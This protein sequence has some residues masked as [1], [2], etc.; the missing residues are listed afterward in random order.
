MKINHILV[1]PPSPEGAERSRPKAQE[2]FNHYLHKAIDAPASLPAQ[3][4]P[5]AGLIQ[6]A[7][8]LSRP[9]PIARGSLEA[10]SLNQAEALLNRLDEYQASLADPKVT[11]K[12]AFLDLE[13][14][15]SGLNSLSS[16]LEKL[17]TDSQG[18]R[19][20]EEISTLVLTQSIKFRRGDYL[21]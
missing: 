19:L 8:P 13:K 10:V 1:N 4:L 14:M 15:E 3:A 18:R 9:A 7:L 12:Q 2:D 11:L 5:S 20:L 17:P 21:D 6:P 16:M